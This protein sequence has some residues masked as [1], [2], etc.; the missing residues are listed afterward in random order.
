LCNIVEF[1]WCVEP[2]APRSNLASN[3]DGDLLPHRTSPHPTARSIIASSVHCILPPAP[4]AR[5]LSTTRAPRCHRHALRSAHRPPQRLLGAQGHHSTLLPGAPPAGEPCAAVRREYALAMQPAPFAR[6][7]L[8]V[9]ATPS[10]EA[11]AAPAMCVA[12][13]RTTPDGGDWRAQ[14]GWSSVL[15]PASCVLCCR[16]ARCGSRPRVRGSGGERVGGGGAEILGAGGSYIRP[17]K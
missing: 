14:T 10:L 1:S 6:R 5:A 3:L 13:S 8:S 17:L 12:T 9:L 7:R 2:R 4:S 16:R 11:L 15:R